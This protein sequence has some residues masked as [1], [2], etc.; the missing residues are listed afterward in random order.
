MVKIVHQQSALCPLAGSK[1]SGLPN[2]RDSLALSGT[3]HDRVFWSK[4][5]ASS[6]MWKIS[7]SINYI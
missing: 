3:S 6:R 4:C 1:P 5:L 7:W 2:A